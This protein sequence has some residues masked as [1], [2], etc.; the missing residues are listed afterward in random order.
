MR[1]NPPPA[2]SPERIA[3]NTLPPPARLGDTRVSTSGADESRPKAK[4]K[5]RKPEPDPTPGAHDR[6]ADART[7]GDRDPVGLVEHALSATAAIEAMS[8]AAA[9]AGGA[10]VEW[11]RLLVGWPA[12]RRAVEG[13]GGDAGDLLLAS[14]ARQVVATLAGM[15][16][17]PGSEVS[18]LAAVVAS[19]PVAVEPDRRRRG[20][21]PAS[22]TDSR[23][24]HADHLPLALDVRTPMGAVPGS[25]EQAHLPGLEPAPSAL[26]PV[27]PIALYDLAGGTMQTRGRGAPVA[28]RLFFEVLMSVGRL[29]R[30]PGKTV[31]VESTYREFVAWLWPNLRGRAWKRE[32]HLPALHRAL[33]EL[34]GMRIEWERQL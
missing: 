3:A 14:S 30:T 32:R 13:E 2:A 26:V 8:D 12:W 4:P 33:L 18:L 9:G 16:E 17:R 22:M 11:V 20:I 28:Q 24:Q 31:R 5:R 23:R 7:R 19:W 25:V 1:D 21:L 6:N 10:P 27:L 34:D 29:D 15:P